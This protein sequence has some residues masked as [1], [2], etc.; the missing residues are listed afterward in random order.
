M[1][2]VGKLSTRPNIFMGHVVTIY[3]SIFLHGSVVI[4]STCPYFSMHY[5][6]IPSTCPH[7]SMDHVGIPFTRSHLSMDHAG[8]SST[9]S[10]VH[11]GI[12]FTCETWAMQ[13]SS[14][15]LSKRPCIWCAAALPISNHPVLCAFQI[16]PD[17]LTSLAS[18][19]CYFQLFRV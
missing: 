7:L 3:T 16:S 4:P 11:M 9:R 19:Q 1:S 14:F 5:V 2:H 8:I 12:L 13:K 10:H 17:I 18:F 6:V 15:I